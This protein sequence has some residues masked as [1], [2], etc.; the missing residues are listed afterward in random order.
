[1]GMW[2]DGQTMWMSPLYQLWRFENVLDRDQLAPGGYDR[3]YVLQ[4]GY[5]TGVSTYTMWARMAKVAS[6]LLTYYLVVWLLSARR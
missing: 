3:F 5:T 6:S 4:V 2:S 1:M